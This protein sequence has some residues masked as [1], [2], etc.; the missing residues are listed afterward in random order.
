MKVSYRVLRVVFVA[1]FLGA[2][3]CAPLGA[4]ETTI[5]F[6]A[7]NPSPED[8][9]C[10]A[11]PHEVIAYAQQSLISDVAKV[12][13]GDTNF[14]HQ[15]WVHI[16]PSALRLLGLKG[17]NSIAFAHGTGTN[18]S[19]IDLTTIPQQITEYAVRLLQS[20]V[21]AQMY[22]ETRNG[23]SSDESVKMNYVSTR[24]KEIEELLMDSPWMRVEIKLQKN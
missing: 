13:N 4:A 2:F 23:R 17:I 11:S 5:N 3:L 22:A 8:E 12:T 24:T 7:T 21:A 18:C 16:E 15:I 1:L 20:T 14:T 9:V 6:P 19:T 10:L